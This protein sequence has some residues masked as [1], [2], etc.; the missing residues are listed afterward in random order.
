MQT[1][2]TL[3]IAVARGIISVEQANSI[4]LIDSEQISN[5]SSAYQA[6]DND[7]EGFRFITG[8]SD[9]FLAIGVIVL[10]SGVLKTNL[11]SSVVGTLGI[12]ALCWGLSEIVATW[13]RRSLPSMVSAAGFVFF[14]T[15]GVFS[16]LQNISPQI[17]LDS[18]EI[19]LLGSAS[20]IW[21][22]PTVMLIV[23]LVY[24]ARFRLPFSLFLSAISFAGL[25]FAGMFQLIPGEYVSSVVIP[26]LL[27]TGFS[28]FCLA[29]YFDMQDTERKTRLS[30]NAFWLHLV[31]SP[32]I[33]HSIMWQSAIW[34][35]GNDEFN[36]RSLDAIALPL[37]VVVLV[38]FVALM[39][40]ALIINRR[41]MLVSSLIYVTL[42]LTYLGS[43]TGGVTSVA[44][45]VPI[46]MGAGILSIGIGWQTLRK[47]L[48]RILPLA[49]ISLHLSPVK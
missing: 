26:V 38:I 40:I 17:L 44:A 1:D 23:A 43:E 30:D 33:V 41:A 31:A 8:F 37:S 35:A 20:D 4:R 15:L 27:V 10:L 19:N 13:Q 42:A 25:M 47:A 45:F 24:Y 9:I 7:E 5:H 49:P 22:I 32:L 18:P 48:F 21:M 3:D 34:L 36:I 2:Q 11:L 12:A 6:N 39:T 46:I 16:Y 14:A 29:I 28:I